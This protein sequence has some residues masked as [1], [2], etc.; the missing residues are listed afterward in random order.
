MPRMAPSR[1]L[2]SGI[3]RSWISLTVAGAAP[4]LQ[5]RNTTHRL[6][7][8][9]LQRLPSGHL[10]RA[11]S[12]AA[13]DITQRDTACK[14]ALTISNLGA[15]SAMLDRCGLGRPIPS[16]LHSALSKHS[17]V[18]EERAWQFAFRMH[19]GFSASC[20]NTEIIHA[21][22]GS[23]WHK[24]ALLCRPGRIRAP[25]TNQCLSRHG[26]IRQGFFQSAAP[27]IQL[28]STR[29][30]ASSATRSAR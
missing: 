8:S 28:C 30:S 19:A 2:H 20:G 24:L 23:Q 9:S 7:V 27:P 26:R 12:S 13:E 11:H 17:R 25:V 16:R 10:N 6:P 15:K 1:A 18:H 22:P 29:Y 3:R 4:A 5:C 21:C 14:D